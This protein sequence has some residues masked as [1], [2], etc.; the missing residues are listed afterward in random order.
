[1]P[2]ARGSINELAGPHLVEKRQSKIGLDHTGSL[3]LLVFVDAHQ[4][5]TGGEVVDQPSRTLIGLERSLAP[6]RFDITLYLAL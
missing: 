3:K 6:Q 4:C 2:P 1:M 5:L